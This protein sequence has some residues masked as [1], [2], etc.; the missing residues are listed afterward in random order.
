MN[1][2]LIVNESPWGSTLANTALR[3]L[4]AALADGSRVRAVYFRDDGVYNAIGGEADAGALDLAG[5]WAAVAGEHGVDLM[6]CSA[7]AARRFPDAAEDVCGRGFRIAGLVEL[8]EE[9]DHCE[10]VVTF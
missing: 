9:M 10:R 6:V 2:L 7:A 8:L 4:R 1:I 3:F 5:E